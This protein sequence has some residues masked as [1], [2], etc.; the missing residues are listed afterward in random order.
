MTVLT[1]FIRPTLPRS[2]LSLAS[3]LNIQADKLATAY[4]NDG[5]CTASAH[6][7]HLDGQQ[8]SISIN[9]VRLTSQYDECLRFHVNGYH[10]KQYAMK[11]N[12]WSNDVWNEIDFGAFG[13]HFRRLRPHQ[14]SSHMKLIHDQLPLGERRYRQATVKDDSL[15][16]CPCCK[17]QPET[18]AHLL[19]CKVNP[20]R[21]SALSKLKSDICT[22]DAHPVRYLLSSGLSH[23]ISTPEELFDPPVSEFPSHMQE[24]IQAALSSQ[25]R[26][27]WHQ[28]AKG[29]LSKHWASLATMDM[30]HPTAI[31]LQKGTTRMRS[32]T[33]SIYQFTDQIWK[34]RNSALHDT[35]DATVAL[36]RSSETAE[37]RHYHAHP[38]LLQF[39]DRHLCSRSLSRLLS[40]SASTRRRWL[41]R[42]KSSI[43]AAARDGT[44]QPVIT[45]F[46]ANTR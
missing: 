29:Y 16:L 14:Q 13:S 5:N 2:S 24:R 42:V 19:Q 1:W 25:A 30:Y 41:R 6:V 22:D 17:V 15:R 35:D 27:G 28:A 39:S 3:R 33:H 32:L 20:E 36:I 23:W 46:F 10:L 8:C 45:S 18:H 34:S 11:S 26:I 21:P 43:D 44:R 7:P 12:G 4:R 40:G 38:S 9:G 31:D 37:I